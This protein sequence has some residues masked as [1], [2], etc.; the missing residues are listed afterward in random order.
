MPGVI[1]A[2]PMATSTSATTLFTNPC[3]RVFVEDPMSKNPLEVHLRAVANEFE[4]L[5]KLLGG[6]EEERWKAIEALKGITSRQI[7]Q[8]VGA[9]L[10]ATAQ[11]L[12]STQLMMK[13]LKENANELAR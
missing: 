2:P 3:D 4:L 7:T 1:R 13:T 12:K 6:T 5:V 8:V 10:E 9:Q 11:S